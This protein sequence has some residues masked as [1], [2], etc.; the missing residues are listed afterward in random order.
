MQPVT[1]PPIPSRGGQPPAKGT[2]MT[3]LRPNRR[4][5]ITGAAAIAAAAVA[6]SAPAAAATVV[7]RQ[8]G[9][10]MLPAGSGLPSWVDPNTDL[11]SRTPGPEVTWSDS[12]YFASMVKAGG[13]DFGVLGHALA[14]PNAQGLAGIYAI[15]VTDTTAGWYKSHST[16]LT[17]E[18]FHWSQDKLE[19]KLPEMTWTGDA[20]RM[21][22]KAAAPWGS[23]DA[24]FV[25]TGP[26]MKY[27][28]SGLVK[29]L[30]VP[31]YEYAFP[32]MRTSGTLV[33][34][35]RQHAITGTAWLDRQWGPLP[36]L[37]RWAWMNLSMPNGDKIAIWDVI[38]ADVEDCWA[39]VLHPDGSY[40]LVAVEPLER[41]ASEPWTSPQ[42]G[43]K[44]PTRF[45]V[46]I[47]SLRT[48]LDVKV[49][50]TPAQE[51]VLVAGVRLEA[52]AAFTGTY[53]GRRVKG[54]HYIELIGRWQ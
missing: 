49:T 53:D 15:S 42:T 2:H 37:L 54:E 6:P 33:I 14:A 1:D 47:P 30:D 12:I 50:G 23:L 34:E 51:L 24:E 11:G 32:S 45:R 36:Q 26:V 21:T 40:E 20:T 7:T 13:H 39:T 17:D 18:Q 27:A 43:Q 4:M 9:D 28:G 44:Y 5:V 22:V 35:G 52:T 48:E 8:P 31:N 19:I 29:L 46:R 10:A 25:P 38:G 41:G 16:T 3:D